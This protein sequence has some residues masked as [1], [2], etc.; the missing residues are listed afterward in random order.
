MEEYIL[1]ENVREMRVARKAEKEVALEKA[2]E[3]ARELGIPEKQAV[4]QASWLCRPVVTDMSEFECIGSHMKTAS[5][6]RE[7]FLQ[8]GRTALGWSV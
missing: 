2:K 4:L 1:V 7:M 5:A 3:I 6:R 8:K